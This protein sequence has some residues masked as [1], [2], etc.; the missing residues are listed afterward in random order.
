MES[1]RGLHSNFAEESR[2]FFHKHLA[3]VSTAIHLA[4]GRKAQVEGEKKDQ[5]HPLSGKECCCPSARKIELTGRARKIDLLEREG[6]HIGIH[7]RTHPFECP[8]VNLRRVYGNFSPA[9]VAA[10]PAARKI[11]HRAI[12]LPGQGMRLDPIPLPRL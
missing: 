8:N 2:A 11:F 1:T 9:F 3:A 10:V 7:P 5:Q 6:L 4:I 12:F